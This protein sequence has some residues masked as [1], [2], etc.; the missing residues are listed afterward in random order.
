M[1]GYKEYTMLEEDYPDHNAHSEYTSDSSWSDTLQDIL[2]I[3]A[4]KSLKIQ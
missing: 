4:A 1:L 2:Q 3:Q